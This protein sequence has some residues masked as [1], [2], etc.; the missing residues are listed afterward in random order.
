M[1]RKKKR[2]TKEFK[3]E[4][5]RLARENEQSIEQTA[6][7]LGISESALRRWLQQADVDEGKGPTGALTTSEREE[8]FQLRRDLRRVTMERDFLKKA[9]AFFAREDS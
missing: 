3:A 5:V 8:L 1:G 7:D 4:A 6:K 2:Y 9:A